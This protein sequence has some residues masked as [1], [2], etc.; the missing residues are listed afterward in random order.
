MKSFRQRY[1]ADAGLMIQ[2]LFDRYDGKWSGRPATVTAFCQGSKWITD[3]LYS[4]VQQKRSNRQRKVEVSSDGRGLL[5][6]DELLRQM[7]QRTDVGS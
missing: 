7:G 6:S 5:T 3:T 4:D 1:D 2:M